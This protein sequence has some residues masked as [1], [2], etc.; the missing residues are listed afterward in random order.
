MKKLLLLI[1]AFTSFSVVGETYKDWTTLAENVDPYLGVPS[2]RAFTSRIS[3]RSDIQLSLSF[4]KD[5]KK[6][7]VAMLT[8]GASLAGDQVDLELYTNEMTIALPLSQG[9]GRESYW[10]VPTSIDALIRQI[11]GSNL[12]NIYVVKEEGRQLYQVSMMGATKALEAIQECLGSAELYEKEFFLKLTDS[13]ISEQVVVGSSSPV[14]LHDLFQMA[15]SFYIQEKQM[16]LELEQ[17]INSNEQSLENQKLINQEYLQTTAALEKSQSSLKNLKLEEQRRTTLLAEEKTREQALSLKVKAAQKTFSLKEAVFL[18]LKENENQMRESL[19]SVSKSLAETR[20]GIESAT[21]LA[22]RSQE[23]LDQYMVQ[24]NQMEFFLT[25]QG[26]ALNQLKEKKSEV[27]LRLDAIN[28]EGQ[29]VGLLG[30][31]LTYQSH[32]KEIQRLKS[33]LPQKESVLSASQQQQLSSQKEFESCRRKTSGSLN[34]SDLC[35]KEMD[36]LRTAQSAYSSA[37]REVRDLNG[38]ISALELECSQIA[39]RYRSQVVTERNKVQKERDLLSEKVFHLENL[40][41]NVSQEVSSLKEAKVPHH[42]EIVTTAKNKIKQLEDALTQ[43]QV[44]FDHLQSEY[45]SFLNTKNF[46]QLE[47]ELNEAK[48]AL[49]LA[50]EEKVQ[51]ELDVKTSKGRLLEIKSEMNQLNE[52]IAKQQPLFKE[53]KARHDLIKKD[54][55]VVLSRKEFL[56]SKISELKGQY[57]LTL[58]H[59]KYV[60][61][62]ILK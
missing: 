33:E 40:I 32:L 15:Y 54:L 13:S 38:Q 7:P 56:E 18:P 34:P 22:M 53:V 27:Q 61:G 60:L 57:A 35:L 28:V 49:R 51:F 16:S 46:S 17:L 8:L 59:Y 19:N 45:E 2:C 5:G 21:Q 20:L 31:D 26:G 37:Q 52:E 36:A 1:S 62:E 6:A 12:I 24:V 58:G 44:T 25:E 50:Q 29:V 43:E 14:R 4:P 11:Q 39:Q 9:E 55:S 48:E 42:Q 3:P 10:Y 30:G 41:G 23:K 47:V